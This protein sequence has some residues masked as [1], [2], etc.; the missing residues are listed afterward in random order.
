MAQFWKKFTYWL[1]EK[2]S[3][4][5]ILLIYQ[6]LLC[7]MILRVICILF[8]RRH[9]EKRRKKA[10]TVGFFHPQCNACSPQENV[11]WSAVKAIQVEYDNV[12]IVVYSSDKSSTPE[13]ILRNVEAKFNI[14]IHPNIRFVRLQQGPW[15]KSFAY[16]GSM[17]V[18]CEALYRLKPHIMIDT[19]GYGFPNPIFKYVGGCR[20]IDYIHN[21]M[22]TIDKLKT[23]HVVVYGNQYVLARRSA[24]ALGLS[25]GI[26]YLYGRTGRAAD[27]VLVNSA[28][29]EENIN[30]IWKCP[31]ITQLIYPPIGLELLMARADAY[32]DIKKEFRILNASEFVPENN[33]EVIIQAYGKML[34]KAKDHVLA[35]TRLILVNLQTSSDELDHAYLQS[36]RDLVKNLDLEDYVKLHP[37]S[38]HPS[39]LEEE[40]IKATYGIY[41]RPNDEFGSDLLA[42]LAT[43]QIIVA[44]ESGASRR[45]LIV[46]KGDERNGFLA[47]S[48]EEYA[49]ALV[50]ALGTSPMEKRRMQKAARRTADQFTRANF[51]KEFLKIFDYFF[52]SKRL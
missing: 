33:H 37:Q 28:Y 8:S 32:S 40:L 50:R 24:S 1:S 42:G 9:V 15:I 22:V 44:H 47:K 7:P 4:L 39:H 30:A 35:T 14:K 23:R 31:Q 45:E 20:V 17:L 18:G 3:F 13:M 10:I 41:A 48:V 49:F 25:K 16:L 29:T 6:I 2:Y 12:Q 27:V 21:P 11:L 26:A 52:E 43:G 38:I 5:K 51:Q 36:L 46:T 19:V 34:S